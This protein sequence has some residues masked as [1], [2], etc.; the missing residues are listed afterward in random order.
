VV[1]SSATMPA[2]SVIIPTHNRA[3]YLREAVDS[4][5]A[6]D[7]RDYELIV[8][9]DGST[10]DTVEILET[11]PVTKK[12]F[13]QH[14]G[15]SAARNTGISQST[16][17]FVAFLDSDD[18]W[19]PTKLRT[20]MAFFA[21]HPQA[22]ICQTEE[23]W[24]RNGVRAHP[25]KRH[26][27]RNGMIFEPSLDLCLVSPSAVMMKRRL[28]DD[29][30]WFDERLP[31]CEDYDLWLRIACR[32]PV[33]LVQSPLVI[34]RGGHRDQLSRRPGLDRFRI[35]ALKKLLENPPPGGLTGRQRGAAME[36]LLKKCTIYAGGCLKRGRFAEARH[37]LTLPQTIQRKD[38]GEASLAID[39]A[40]PNRPS[41]RSGQ[42]L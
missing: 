12:I 15:V 40:A 34:K 25:K 28:L 36:A 27:K 33:N 39:G 20:Q 23:I 3:S 31:A 8:V 41:A 26:R 13:Q 19:L 32:L 37:Y 7:F 16:G 29:V 42:G 17:T 38:R 1:N 9:D 14:S 6:Q 2:I 4:V 10:D 30:G 21:N 11:R 18:L 22:L 5:L 24:L 35:Y